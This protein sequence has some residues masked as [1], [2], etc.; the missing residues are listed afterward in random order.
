MG[1][2]VVLFHNGLADYSKAKCK[3][4]L[5]FGGPGNCPNHKRYT[6]YLMACG[7]MVPV[8][9]VPKFNFYY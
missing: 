9:F 6:V 2:Y 7:F 3:W 8:P 5:Y 1:T 4:N